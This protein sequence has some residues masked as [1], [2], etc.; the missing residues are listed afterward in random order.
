MRAVSTGQVNDQLE[1]TSCMDNILFFEGLL[2]GP[3]VPGHS[4]IGIQK[5][6]NGTNASNDFPSN[7][8]D[9]ESS[10]S[11]CSQ[12]MSVRSNNSTSF[13]H[14]QQETFIV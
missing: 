1:F 5:G 11:K 7:C 13:N 4:F 9:H 8:L 12:V 10:Q 6:I 14:H 3:V 2:F